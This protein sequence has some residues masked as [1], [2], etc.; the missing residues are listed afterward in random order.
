MRLPPHSNDK[1]DENAD[2]NENG[3][4]WVPSEAYKLAHDFR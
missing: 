4:D 1:Q 3:G 2:L